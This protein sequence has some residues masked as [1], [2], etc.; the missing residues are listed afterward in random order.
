MAIAK[1]I[2]SGIGAGAVW[3]TAANWDVN[4]VPVYG[5][6]YTSA[7][8]NG[9]NVTFAVDIRDVDIFNSA[10]A[11]ATLSGSC[12]GVTFSSS[13]ITL[14]TDAH[15]LL[16]IGCTVSGGIANSLVVRSAG[17]LHVE[18]TC[19]LTLS[20]IAVID[21][22]GQLLIK[23]PT[24]TT[25]KTASVLL[26]SS[27]LN[28][29][30]GFNVILQPQQITDAAARFTI[31]DGIVDIAGNLLIDYTLNVVGGD[32]TTYTSTSVTA[33]VML[34]DATVGNMLFSNK[35]L[36][37]LYVRD[38]GGVLVDAD[39]ITV[40]PLVNGQVPTGNT[41]GYFKSDVGRYILAADLS[42]LD[43]PIQ[44]GD[45]VDLY[46]EITV[47]SVITGKWY[48]T[49]YR[50]L[51][52][53][54]VAGMSVPIT[55]AASGVLAAG[56]SNICASVAGYGDSVDLILR[57]V[58][59]NNTLSGGVA[60]NLVGTSVGLRCEGGDEGQLNIAING[61][62]QQ[63]QG[64]IA[65][66]DNSSTGVSGVGLRC[67][68]SISGPDILLNASGTILTSTSTN[69]IADGVDVSTLYTN[70]GTPVALDGGT[71]SVVGMLTKLADDAGGSSFD[72]TT[73][74]LHAISLNI[75]GTVNTIYI[76][77]INGTPGQVLHVNGTATNPSSNYDD[78]Y[79]LAIAAG[80]RTFTFMPDS[81][82]TLSHAHIN[83]TFEGRGIIHVGGQDISDAVF[84]DCETVDGV[85]SNSD[86]VHFERSTIGDIS[87][88]SSHWE[89][90]A[91]AGKITCQTSGY[92]TFHECYDFNPGVGITP[93]ISLYNAANVGMRNYRG[94][95]VLS[96]M[97]S[98]NQ[99]K[100][101]GAGRV[102]LDSTCIDGDLTVRGFFP[103]ITY[104]VGVWLGTI[105]DTQRY[106]T[107][108]EVALSS[109]T[110]GQIATILSTADVTVVSP[111]SVD[112]ESLSLVIDDDYTTDNGQPIQ[113][114]NT[115]GGWPDLTVVGASCA[116]SIRRVSNNNLL[117][118]K[119]G[120]A[121]IIGNTQT[122][123]FE[124]TH[125][126]TGKMAS[127]VGKEVKFDVQC[128]VD[129]EYRTL[130]MGTCTL[131]G[132]IHRW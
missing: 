90:C 14:E 41:A 27:T 128:K 5:G 75:G 9:K 33:T 125:A 85:S 107:D 19:S 68:G 57:S 116:L 67:A 38:P 118:R 88:G 110:I 64:A 84:M 77:T 72:A 26:T 24:W 29:N 32:L 48:H 35:L 45:A 8:L 97:A 56:L 7:D 62:G 132:V 81:V 76:D 131:E 16:S 37:P 34:D 11:D 104:T 65:G 129:N 3:G 94:G 69:V 44:V 101:D 121:E 78:A 6:T 59:V 58:A 22:D 54:I 60:V 53:D 28:I 91:L 103:P 23:A 87:I 4:T 12:T 126:E 55:E 70:V 119:I 15:M 130:V 102:E 21:I 120:T 2:G 30:G 20:S 51:S 66:V 79:A 127:S 13:T 112:G 63:N 10:V 123:T 122:L 96:D 89:N 105:T 40:T 73:D 80:V 1:F 39:A 106:G 46:V 117:V 113:F 25:A 114:S 124:L 109:G 74:S 108:Q 86:D 95:V 43:V 31:N 17:V 36:I 92:Y 82:I 99:V 115:G 100:V 93:N 61:I 83:W 111:L 42:D 47:G 98:T 18:N 71:A 52:A 50:G 49:L